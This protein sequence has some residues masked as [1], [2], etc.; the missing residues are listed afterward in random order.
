MASLSRPT[1][2]ELI[3]ARHARAAS[4]EML[5]LVLQLRAL[6]QATAVPTP[7][8]DTLWTAVESQAERYCR[9]RESE[10]LVIKERPL[11]FDIR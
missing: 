7:A 1:G 3:F 8:L 11:G 5:E 9:S 4:A 2:A 6:I 10:P